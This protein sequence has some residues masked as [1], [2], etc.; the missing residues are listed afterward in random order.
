MQCL[1]EGPAGKLRALPIL[2]LSVQRDNH[3]TGL[4]ALQGGGGL[5]GHLQ[6]DLLATQKDQ[7]YGPLLSGLGQQGSS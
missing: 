1:P 6:K 4:R 3:S 5:G 7:L 2:P